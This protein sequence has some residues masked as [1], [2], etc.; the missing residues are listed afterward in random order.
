M[1]GAADVAHRASL[2]GRDGFHIHGTL[3]FQPS[4]RF[5]MNSSGDEFKHAVKSCYIYFKDLYLFNVLLSLES[6]VQSFA[7]FTG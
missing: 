7:C 4:K 3:V 6:R 1:L 5:S 2:V